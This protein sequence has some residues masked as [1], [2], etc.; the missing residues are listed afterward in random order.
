MAGLSGLDGRVARLER[1]APSSAAAGPCRGC[2]LRHVPRPSIGVV[3][4]VARWHLGGGGE[5]PEPM[6]LCPC[7]HDQRALAL[8][9]HAPGAEGP[10][11]PG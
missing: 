2:G 10:T 7:C 5:R 11:W 1:A 8:L 6:C 9:T 3:E 4:Q